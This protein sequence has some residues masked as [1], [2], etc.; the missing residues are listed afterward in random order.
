MKS[1][2]NILHLIDSGGLYGAENVIINLSTCL[3]KRGHRSVIGSF[4]YDGKPKQEVGVRAADLGLDTA[5]FY[6]NNKI[7]IAVVTKIARYC[8]QNGIQII[9]SHGYKPSIMCFVI[10]LIYG[11]PYVVTCHLWYLRNLRLRIYAYLE[12]LTMFKAKAIIGVSQDIVN[13]LEKVGVP[14]KKLSLIHNGIDVDL[15]SKVEASSA[16]ELRNRLGLQKNSFIIGSLGR[17]TE[18]KDYKT[19]VKAAS[20]ILKEE[21]DVE[22]IVAG[23][24]HLKKELISLTKQLEIET[25]FHFVGFQKEIPCLLTLMDI[26]VLSSLDEGL[27]MA[28]LEAMAAKRPIVTTAVG[29]IPTLITEGVNGRIIHQKNAMHIKNILLSLKIDSEQRTQ[30]AKSAFN[31]V[32]S[33][34]SNDQMTKNYLDIYAPILSH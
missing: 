23:E 24:G 27:P 21:N 32:N 17:L 7:D 1:N 16:I 14:S 26:F 25:K 29:A 2:L 20:E 13:R 6:M 34:F 12:K 9:H 19:L 11:I 3:K 30:L 8:K 18:Q 31:L 4:L 28:L 5:F 15:Y 22:F 33:M 10:N